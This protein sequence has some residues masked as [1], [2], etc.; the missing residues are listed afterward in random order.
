MALQTGGPPVL[1]SDLVSALS[2][3]SVSS[4][5]VTTNALTPAQA[6]TPLAGASP[7][8]F[9]AG[10]GN[11]DIEI[12]AMRQPYRFCYS[13]DLGRSLDQSVASFDLIHIHS[14]NLYPQYAAWRAAEKNG[15]PYLVTPNL[16]ETLRIIQE[17]A[18]RLCHILRLVWNHRQ[19]V[20]SVRCR[21]QV[22]LMACDYSLARCHCFSHRY[23]E[24][25]RVRWERPDVGRSDGI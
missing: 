22:D 14:V 23:A 8:D 10:A 25:F 1:V 4:R 18:D 15:V 19:S 6:Q 13:P 17:L 11:L 21:C 12:H 16:L 24:I 5:I 7:N 20:G 9:P 2:R 3:L